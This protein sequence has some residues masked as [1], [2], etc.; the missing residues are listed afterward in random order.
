MGRFFFSHFIML[1]PKNEPKSKKL[2]IFIDKELIS[3]FCCLALANSVSR[4][5]GAKGPKR[6]QSFQVFIGKWNPSV[7]GRK[8]HWL[9]YTQKHTCTN[10]LKLKDTYMHREKQRNT[11]CQIGRYTH[12]QRQTHIHI[13]KK[14]NV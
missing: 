13:S 12:R 4:Y 9:K 6:T 3:F 2:N 8:T 7:S 14:S 5:W 10:K 1:F 11:Q